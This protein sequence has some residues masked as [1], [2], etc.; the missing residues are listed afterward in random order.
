MGNA[1]MK[2]DFPIK[3][4]GSFCLATLESRL[5]SGKWQIINLV[6]NLSAGVLQ[7]STRTSGRGGG[8]EAEHNEQHEVWARRPIKFNSLYF[9]HEAMRD[10]KLLDT[11]FH[12]LK[13]VLTLIEANSS[14]SGFDTD[15]AWDMIQQKTVNV[16]FYG[17]SGAGKS[18]L[19]KALTGDSEINTSA[20]EQVQ[21]E[22]SDEISSPL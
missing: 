4:G 6:E 14:T 22:S 3:T 9:A 18:S 17:E 13:E 15:L 10:S 12:R 19:V 20:T 7:M 16:L 21:V 5:D 1:I 2:L 8:G 11:F